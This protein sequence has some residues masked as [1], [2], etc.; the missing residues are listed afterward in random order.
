MKVRTG[1][2]VIAGRGFGL[3]RG[4]RVGLLAH[5]ASVD[6]ELR[7]VVDLLIQEELDLRVIF[8]PEHGLSG[9]AQD[10]R[11]VGD[12]SESSI[13]VI[14][15]YGNDAAS[16]VPAREHITDLDVLVVDLQDVGCRYYTYA[17][18]M[19]Y[20]MKACAAV[21]VRVVVL[22]RPNPLN[23][24]S[25]EGPGLDERFRSFVG[26]YSVPV[27]HGLTIGELARLAASDLPGLDLLVVEMEGWHRRMWFDQT[28]L[29]WVMPSPNMPALTSAS[30]Y[31]GS[32][33]VEATNVSEGRGTTR[34]FEI[35]G[36][37]WLHEGEL[38]KALERQG[39]RGVAFR[40][41]EFVPAFGKHAGQTCHGIQ[42]H[43]LDR[44]VF[45]PFRFG[46]SFLEAARQVAP[47]AFEW[48]SEPY[49][50]VSDVLAIDLLCGGP[51]VRTLLEQGG[52]AEYMLE[53]WRE[54]AV[55]FSSRRKDVLLYDEEAA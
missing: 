51:E 24:V 45:E 40:R 41:L 34:P 26:E 32:C 18:T 5:Q 30:V 42:V 4:Q 2:D 10:M 31:P 21:G 12:A 33:L 13:P 14:S 8:G 16:L 23:G 36:A 28:G 15:L 17:A 19:L 20:C 48:R 49:E 38:V 37:P 35:L 55:E 47:D 46:F 53:R 3:V 27:R 43:V 1:L 9:A 39:I 50:F 29:P 44:N 22:D 6:H 7:H 11:A 25:I 52:S 54:Q